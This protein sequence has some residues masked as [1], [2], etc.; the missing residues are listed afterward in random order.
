MSNVCIAEKVLR[1]ERYRLATEA[2]EE[3]YRKQYIT[4]EK[5]SLT[6]KVREEELK[7]LK[8]KLK[9]CP[10]KFIVPVWFCFN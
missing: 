3:S 5:F 1:K 2:E 10:N 8:S 4:G 7:E 6:K 9:L